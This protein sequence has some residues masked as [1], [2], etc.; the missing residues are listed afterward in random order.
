[1]HDQFSENF[2]LHECK[3]VKLNFEIECHVKIKTKF[4][5]IRSE[6]ETGLS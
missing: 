4:F 6:L 2:P 5:I 1:M 3:W